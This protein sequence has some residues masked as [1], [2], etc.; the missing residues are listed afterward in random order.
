MNGK[1]HQLELETLSTIENFISYIK[2]GTDL[3]YN[4][5]EIYD[6][7]ENLYELYNFHRKDGKK[8]QQL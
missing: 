8:W 4:D 7:I 3:K 1:M 6:A 2:F 5:V